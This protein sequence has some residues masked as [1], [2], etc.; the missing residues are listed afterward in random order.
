MPK[1]TPVKGINIKDLKQDINAPQPT[2]ENDL[3]CL[4]CHKSVIE[5]VILPACQQPHIYCMSCANKM[6]KEGPPQNPHYGNYRENNKKR[7][8]EH[9]IQC[10]LCSSESHLDPSGGLASLRRKKKRKLEDKNKC[11][12]HN[13]EFQMFCLDCVELICVN[14][15]GGAHGKHNTEALDVAQ[16]KLQSTFQSKT[17][18]MQK[19]KIK[20]GT[21]YRK[22]EKTTISHSRKSRKTSKGIQSS[23]RNTQ[24]IIDCKRKRT[25]SKHTK[26]C[27]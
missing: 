26:Y 23:D 22:C 7:S 27:K 2:I 20:I 21:I 13:E 4:I 19:K 3:V 25:S 14:C 24:T 5:Y 10:V 8:N 15:L 17:L 11:P 6:I 18:E 16:K 9:T 1:V 12:E